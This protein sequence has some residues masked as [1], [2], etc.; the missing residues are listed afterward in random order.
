MGSAR[1][2][3]RRPWGLVLMGG[4]ARGL[5]HI[6][7]LHA[8][9]DHGLA[10]DVIA[11]TSM[12]ALVGAFYAAGMT[13]REIESLTADFRYN[14]VID[15]RLLSR[16]P[17]S[18]RRFFEGLMLGTRADRLLRSLGI[19][20]EDRVEAVLGRIV[21]GLRIEDLPIPFACNAVDI[22][23]GREVVFTSGPLRN[24]LRATMAFP[25]VFEP[26]RRQGRLLVDGGLLDN[27]PVEAARG[28]G[29]RKVVV[30]DTHKSLREI[31]ASS[32]RNVFQLLARTSTIVLTRA[33]E[34]QLERADLVYRIEVDVATFDF[35]QTRAI[36]AKGRKAT[37]GNIAAIRRLVSG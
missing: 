10:P 2:R 28:L 13:P 30:P 8:L 32:I 4:G 36:I 14:S 35:S 11:G 26:A 21:G 27:V 31:P 34:S 5:A 20:R 16:R 23:T 9:D 17:Q 33:T 3:S 24:A 12:G 7:V 1:S 29:A 22:V 15:R 6:G 18:M 19:D 25:L 37:E